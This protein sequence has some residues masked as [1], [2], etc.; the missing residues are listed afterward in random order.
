[1]IDKLILTHYYLPDRKPF[2]NLS[3]LEEN[4][5]KLVLD[6]LREKNRRGESQRVFMDWYVEDRKESER[7]LRELFIRKG[8]RPE[9]L[10]PHYFVLG[11]S[12]IQKSLAKNTRE[13]EIPL[14]QIPAEFI[15]FTYPDSMASFDLLNEPENKMPYH[16]ELF[17]L[18]EILNVIQQYGMPAD[19]IGF[20]SR[21]GYPKY[22]EAQL[23][24]DQPVLSFLK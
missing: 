8:G 14:N 6:D 7:K 18:E 13:L 2:L 23:W 17:L 15:S 21:Y 16:G 10:F 22:I 19:E 4:E 20:T 11:K 1:M 12:N 9:K 3:G 24:S 5:L